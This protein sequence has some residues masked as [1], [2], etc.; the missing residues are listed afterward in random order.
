MCACEAI[1]PL[2]PVIFCGRTGTGK[3]LAPSSLSPLTADI[4]FPMPLI[5]SAVTN[6]NHLE[7]KPVKHM[8]NVRMVVDANHNLAF[9]VLNKVGHPF[10]TFKRKIHT[11]ALGLP[12]RRI[13]V[14]KSVRAIVALSTVQPGQVFNVGAI[15]PLPCC[16]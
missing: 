14:M 9:A 13:H 1:N 12:V 11:I 2:F 10:V 16:R 3:H 8:P 7:E 6:I 5:V 4:S 15:Q